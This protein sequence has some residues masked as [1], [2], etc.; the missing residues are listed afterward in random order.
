MGRCVSIGIIRAGTVIFTYIIIL[1]SFSGVK[2]QYAYSVEYDSTDS[3]H[4]S[5]NLIKVAKTQIATDLP[6]DFT[7]TPDNG[8]TSIPEVCFLP[9]KLYPSRQKQVCNS[10]PVWTAL[11]LTMVTI[12]E[13]RPCQLGCSVSFLYSK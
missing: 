5:A 8:K 3:T 4:T 7:F 12:V 6:F 9:G 2:L 1:I 10:I 13:S 11:S